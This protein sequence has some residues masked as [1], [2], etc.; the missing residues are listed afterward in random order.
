MYCVKRENWMTLYVKF[1]VTFD[2]SGVNAYYTQ[3]LI[4]LVNLICAYL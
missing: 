4:I 2:Q 3:T 1:I